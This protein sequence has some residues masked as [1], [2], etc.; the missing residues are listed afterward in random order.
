MMARIEDWRAA[1][2]W[3]PETIAAATHAWFHH[4]AR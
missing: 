4:L 2:L 3:T 1:P